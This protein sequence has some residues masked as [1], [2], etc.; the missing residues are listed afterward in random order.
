[1][2]SALS[3]PILS[4]EYSTQVPKEQYFRPSYLTHERWNSFWYQIHIVRSLKVSTVL[5]IG[6]GNG[7]VAETLRKLNVTIATL[8]IDAS[9]TPD[10]IGSVTKIPLPDAS[11]DL[12]LAAEILEHIAWQDFRQA[13]K[14]IH[15]VSREYVVVS[16]PHSG[17][18][19]ALIWKFPLLTWKY[20]VIKLP[21][22]W[23]THVF[24]GEHYWETGKKRC[25]IK[26][27][28]GEF[29][30]AG[31]RILE[32]TRFPDDPAHF[33]FKLQKN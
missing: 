21:H 20:W 4:M 17:Y 7:I 26:R 28:G 30:K 10:Y 18:T 25:S 29:E 9:L 24:N 11:F 27:V 3:K 2:V 22:F 1:M 15:R 32:A 13:L 8:D 31:F 33:Y 23:K 12:I 19:F 14:E 5:E 16:L 6:V